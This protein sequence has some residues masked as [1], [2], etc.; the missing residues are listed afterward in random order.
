ML[1]RL[2]A[3]SL[4][5]RTTMFQ[6][7]SVSRCPTRHPLTSKKW[8]HV[9]ID[10]CNFRGQR[11]SSRCHGNGG[12]LEKAVVAI[13]LLDDGF[14]FHADTSLAAEESTLTTHRYLSVIY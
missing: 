6:D 8:S 4:T 7:T 1:I 3:F 11:S 13:G 10:A 5:P 2:V 14:M 12:M 9:E